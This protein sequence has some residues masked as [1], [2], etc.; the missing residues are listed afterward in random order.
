MND[1]FDENVLTN[2][3]SGKGLKL[4]HDELREIN[5]TMHIVNGQ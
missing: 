4:L 1:D 5:I 2:Y 3:N